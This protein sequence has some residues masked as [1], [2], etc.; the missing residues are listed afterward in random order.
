MKNTIWIVGPGRKLYIELTNQ[1]KALG[2]CL[3]EN[4]S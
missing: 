3:L 1:R 4:N 2:E